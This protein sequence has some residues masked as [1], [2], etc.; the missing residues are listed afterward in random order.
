MLRVDEYEVS[1]YERLTLQMLEVGDY[2]R[3]TFKMLWVGDYAWI[4]VHSRC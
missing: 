3:N 1:D 2:E 4:T